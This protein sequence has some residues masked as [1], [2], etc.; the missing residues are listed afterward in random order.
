MNKKIFLFIISA[1]SFF[2]PPLLAQ[3]NDKL[4]EILIQM[5]GADKEIETLEVDFKQN[6]IFTETK[7]KQNFAGRLF[8]SKPKNIL[9]K[10]SAPQEQE[11]Y[12]NG[13]TLTIYTPK[14]S[15]AIISD[16]SKNAN[17][18]FSPA[19]FINFGGNWANLQKENIINYVSEN[20]AEY[21]LEVYPKKNKNWMMNVYISKETMNANRITVN[22]DTLSVDITLS[23]Y[24]INQPLDKQSLRFKPSKNIDV[25]KL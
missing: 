16:I 10:R 15:Q 13:N 11:I 5:Q 22:S 4:N 18:D 20:D 3:E 12:I 2:G 14:T 9:I 1:L 25:I 17:A 21:V 6:I 23:N 24:K 7:E 19:S 8:F